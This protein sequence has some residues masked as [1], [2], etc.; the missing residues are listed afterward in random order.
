M[1]LTNHRLVLIYMNLAHN[2]YFIDTLFE[3]GVRKCVVSLDEALVFLYIQ[4][5]TSTR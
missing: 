3:E 5:L 1:Q 2:V 4:Q